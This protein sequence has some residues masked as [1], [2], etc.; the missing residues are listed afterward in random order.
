MVIT[1]GKAAAGSFGGMPGCR[2]LQG[3]GWADF[4][5]VAEASAARMAV[6]PSAFR[7]ALVGHVDALL[8]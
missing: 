1:T 7:D 3:I 5:I 8:S 2:Q 4:S 6:R